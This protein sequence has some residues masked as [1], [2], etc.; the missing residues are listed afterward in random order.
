MKV[1]MICSGKNGKASII[2]QRQAKSIADQGIDTVLF[3]IYKGGFSGYLKSVPILRKEL[4]STQYD[5]VHAHY[6]LCGIIFLLT[7]V[8]KPIVISFMG[9]DILG[10]VGNEKKYTFAG[11][12]ISIVNRVC[13]RF[14]YNFSIVKSLQM[15][16]KLLSDTSS[17]IIPNGVDLEVFYPIDHQIAKEELELNMY[18]AHILFAS[19]KMRDEK[20]FNL[21]S[22]AIELIT[23]YE[24]HLLNVYSC[25]QTELNKYYNA[26][27]VVVLSS[28]HEGS[29]NVI[30]EAMACNCPIVSTDVGDV[31]WVIG[32]TEGCYLASYDPHDFAAKIINAIEF[33]KTKGRT[34]GRSRIIELGLDDKTIANKIIEVYKKVIA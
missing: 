17:A 6:G 1:L 26:V 4:K 32:E 22:E 31:K 24:C 28:F 34:N 10:S 13:A 2:V 25:N 27:D 29:P 11:W 20:N 23:N 19:N 5:I 21:V 33:S 14:V 9:D 30:K 12:I 7:L 8:K 3:L 15:R 16:N 18:Q